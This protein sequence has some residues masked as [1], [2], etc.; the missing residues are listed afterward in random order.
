MKYISCIQEKNNW[1]MNK[2]L[3]RNI[4][5]ENQQLIQ[6]VELIERQFVYNKQESRICFFNEQKA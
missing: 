4:I 6:G 3:V 2:Y 5:V 1:A